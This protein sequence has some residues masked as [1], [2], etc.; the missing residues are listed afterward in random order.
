MNLWSYNVISTILLSNGSP[1]FWAST[2]LSGRPPTSVSSRYW[3]SESRHCCS[4]ITLSL[5]PCSRASNEPSRRFHNQGE[6]TYKGLFQVES[7]YYTRPVESDK[8]QVFNLHQQ[9]SHRIEPMRGELESVCQTVSA[10][11][12]GAQI[13]S[14]NV[15]Q[16]KAPVRWYVCKIT[17]YLSIWT[18]R[19]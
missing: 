18:R 19:D 7:A 16:K 11:K 9:S 5:A 17:S 2:I 3:L 12:S 15:N 4:D 14:T 1:N 13:E 6:G 10:N 8:Y